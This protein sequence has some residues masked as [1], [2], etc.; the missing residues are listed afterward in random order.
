[1]APA[2]PNT[3]TRALLSLAFVLERLVK[4]PAW[5]PRITPLK[6]AA[7][8]VP[9]VSKFLCERLAVMLGATSED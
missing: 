3:R 1:M 2:A 7:A 6:Q 8:V 9:H 4:H 5:Q